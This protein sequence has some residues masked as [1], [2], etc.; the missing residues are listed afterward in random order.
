MAKE[1]TWEDAVQTVLRSTSESLHYAEIA[2]RV[3]NEKIKKIIG[4]TPPATVAATL[5][6]IVRDPS[7]G[8]RRLGGGYYACELPG[9]SQT[10]LDAISEINTEVIEAGAL[11]AFGMFWRRDLVILDSKPKLLGRQSSA[12][13]LV[14]FSGQVGVYLLHDRDR[15]IYVGRASESLASRLKAHTTDR[16]S[17]RWDRFSWFGLKRVNEA[18]ELSEVIPHWSVDVVI[19][20]MEA[21]LI[22]SLEPPL[23]RRRGDN[24]A[25]IEYIQETDPEIVKQER[26]RLLS[27]MANKIG[28]DNF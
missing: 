28:L 9:Y 10:N 25:S 24:L 15:V 2:D 23:N 18:G 5:A 20:T 12:K 8:I 1:P 13:V 26:K 27:E 6:R 16:L 11:S 17:G 14:N 3:V 19:D 21:L 4:A 22:E 7:R